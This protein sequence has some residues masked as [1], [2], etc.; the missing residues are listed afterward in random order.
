VVLFGTVH[1][2]IKKM[3]SIDNIVAK[4]RAVQYGRSDDDRKNTGT[5]VVV[6]G[7]GPGL[8]I[9]FTHWHASKTGIK[10]IAKALGGDTKTAIV[11][12]NK[13]LVSDPNTTFRLFD[14]H[15]KKSLDLTRGLI[16]S[17]TPKTI[18][19]IGISIGCVTACYVASELKLS[20]MNVDLIT[21]GA[22][23]ATSLWDSS[24]TPFIRKFYAKKGYTKQSLSTLWKPL[25]PTSNLG[26]VKNNA[27]RVFYSL[28]D[29][30]IPRMEG[31]ILIEK[32][33]HM[34]PKSLKVVR[35]RHLGHYM[36]LMY[37]W[38][39]WPKLYRLGAK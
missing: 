26:F 39:L 3:I 29:T 25:A 7:H 15:N 33:R 38:L 18:N 35:N 30:A 31:Q 16:A 23:L 36:T 32:I 22:D 12:A 10:N 2:K 37:V 8:T 13:L 4:K 17:H 6:T 21:P 27:T 20:G 5:K 34:S 28:A 19:I 9:V 1:T 14:D 11:T 24:R